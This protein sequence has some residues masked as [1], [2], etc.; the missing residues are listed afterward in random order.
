MLLFF[1]ASSDYGDMPRLRVTFEPDRNENAGIVSIR[2][3]DIYEGNE[4]FLGILSLPSGSER[5]ALGESIA[6]V[7][8]LDDDG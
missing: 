8:I 3:D 6:I 4:T 7:T 2:N 1:V 5:V